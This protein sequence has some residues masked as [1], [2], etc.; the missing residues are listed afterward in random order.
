MKVFV[1]WSGPRS[2]KIALALA[3]HI[4]AV[5]NGAEPWLSKHI[6]AGT[7]WNNEINGRLAVSRFGILVLTDGNKNAPWLL[8]E[9]GAIAKGLDSTR[10]VPYLVDM[11]FSDIPQGPLTQFQG[12]Q[13]DEEG[14][15]ALLESINALCDP[16]LAQEE[17]NRRFTSSWP[18][19]QDAIITRPAS[20]DDYAEDDELRHFMSV[21]IDRFALSGNEPPEED[22]R[23]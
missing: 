23:G 6:A 9:A 19:L 13:A 10:V 11:E 17:V 15:S 8:F 2:G 7:N 21:Q 12:V 18:D 22:R 3:T 20:A 5:L 4:K 1:S 16:A 14:T